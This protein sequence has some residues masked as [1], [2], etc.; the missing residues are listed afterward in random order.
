[1]AGMT[2]QLTA[3]TVLSGLNVLLLL[4][5]SAVWIR[6]YVKFHSAMILGLVGFA[7]VLLFEN[8]VALYFFF[9]MGMLYSGSPLAQTMVLAMRSLQFVALI[10][11][12]YVSMK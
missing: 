2:S 3:A 5:L 6:N 7:V 9:S 8:V 1:M 10:F 12:T 11:L 4:A